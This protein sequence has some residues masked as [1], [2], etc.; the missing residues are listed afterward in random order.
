MFKLQSLKKK[1]KRRLIDTVW[2]LVIFFSLQKKW[3]FFYLLIFDVPRFEVAH[4]DIW[5]IR[6]CLDYNCDTLIL[7]N[8]VGKIYMWDLTGDD[9]SRGKPH[10]LSH[11]KCTAAIRQVTI[12]RDGR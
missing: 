1:S 10:L 9:P 6:F 11:S 4:C 3:C 7:G 12:S 2:L 8:Q 5:Y